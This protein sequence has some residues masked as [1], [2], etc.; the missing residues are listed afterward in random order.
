MRMRKYGIGL[1]A[2]WGGVMIGFILTAAFLVENFWAYY[3][4]IAACAIVCFWLAVKVEKTVI[5]IMTSFIGAYAGVRGVSFYI[6]GFPNEMELRA[7][8]ADGVINWENYDKKFFIYLGA[9]LAT[10][11]IGTVY[12]RKQEA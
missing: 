11:I 5:I 9:M 1:V 3:G 10:T 4:I 2:G 8:L 6:G 7:E 12:Q